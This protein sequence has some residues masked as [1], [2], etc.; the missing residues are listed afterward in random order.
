MRLSHLTSANAIEGDRAPH[1]LDGG[2]DRKT[3]PDSGAELPAVEHACGNGVPR[4]PYMLPKP[5]LNRGIARPDR[6][7]KS[8]KL[9]SLGLAAMLSRHRLC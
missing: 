6:K 7:E 9:C 3:K 8:M 2:D 5:S 1:R 4:S